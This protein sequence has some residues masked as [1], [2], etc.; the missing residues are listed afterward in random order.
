MSEFA[1]IFDSF[2]VSG[3]E[4]AGMV[5]L[6]VISYKL[7]KMRI[8]THSNCCDGNVDVVTDNTGRGDDEMGV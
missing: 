3:L 6:L 8:R 7:Y 4:G 2:I 1:D 5:L